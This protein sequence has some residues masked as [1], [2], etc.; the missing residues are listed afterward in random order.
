MSKSCATRAGEIPENENGFF[1]AIFSIIYLLA[2]RVNLDETGTRIL[3][4]LVPMFMGMAI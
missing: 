4:A 3:R 1:R 2:H